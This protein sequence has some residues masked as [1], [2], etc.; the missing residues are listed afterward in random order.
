MT[1]KDER[2]FTV[3]CIPTALLYATYWPTTPHFRRIELR[4]IINIPTTHFVTCEAYDMFK[5]LSS[6]KDRHC[7]AH[8]DLRVTEWCPVTM[9]C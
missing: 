6:Y 9:R 1:K 2:F 8:G 3:E 5:L 4:G 7:I